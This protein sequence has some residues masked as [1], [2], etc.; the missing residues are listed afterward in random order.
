[1]SPQKDGSSRSLTR[2]VRIEANVSPSWS[3][4]GQAGEKVPIAVTDFNN[5]RIFRQHGEHL[6]AKRLQKAGPVCT[7]IEHQVRLCHVRDGIV[8]KCRVID[9]L[10][11]Q[12]A[13]VFKLRAEA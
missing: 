12:A 10:A 13:N 3:G 5:R 8:G 6:L 9:V 11:I 7:A 1:M 2:A 4:F